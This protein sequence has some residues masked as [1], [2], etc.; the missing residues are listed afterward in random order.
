MSVYVPLNIKP[1]VLSIVKYYGKNSAPNV[2]IQTE[3]QSIRQAVAAAAA[4]AAVSAAA[5]TAVH[6]REKDREESRNVSPPV[7]SS[8]SYGKRIE[9]NITALSPEWPPTNNKVSPQ[10]PKESHL[11][12]AAS[13]T[14][15][16]PKAT[17]R[18]IIKAVA[19]HKIAPL[20]RCEFQSTP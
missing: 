1:K 10:L 16:P 20:P 18:V 4:A 15:T 3:Q 13:D 12:P 5:A 19:V 9:K 8:L 11:R 14:R 17:N 7:P 2:S 6:D